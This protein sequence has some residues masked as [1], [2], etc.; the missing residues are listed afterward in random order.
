M[1]RK[2]IIKTAYFTIPIILLYGIA[3]FLRVRTESPDVLRMGMFPNIYMHYRDQFNLSEKEKFER[4]SHTK[5]NNFEFLTIGDSFSDQK[6]YGYNHFLAE[7]YS[8]LH[9]DH[10]IANNQIQTLINL[11]NGDF[12]DHYKVK[13][14][15]LQHVERNFI[16]NI[17][18]IDFNAKIS[19][20]QIDSIIVNHHETVIDQK[21]S[22]FFSRPTLEF[23]LYDLPKFFICNNYLSNDLIYN[24]KLNSKKLFSNH[25]DKLLFYKVDLISTSQNNNPQNVI[26]L[27]NILNKISKKLEQK[28]IKLIILP[29]PDKYDFYYD[30]IIDKSNLKKPLFFEYFQALKKDYLY[31]NSKELLKSHINKESN[32][33]FYDDTHWSPVASKIIANEISKFVQ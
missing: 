9:V 20:S 16:T 3:M 23:P 30:Y 19:K 15:I 27:N 29:S 6:G 21:D 22:E 24:Y 31:I 17:K 25:S 33:Y 32:I 2:L 4:V 12:F 28:N 10:Y 18:E 7:K 13:Y 26:R 8:T 14:V 5:K 11:V 1:I